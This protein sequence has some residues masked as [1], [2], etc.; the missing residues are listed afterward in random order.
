MGDELN[1]ECAPGERAILGG[2]GLPWRWV[3]E[4]ALRIETGDA[5]LACHAALGAAG[6]PE[7]EDV[8]PA[9]GSLLL[10][11]R[12]GAGVP[13]G[14]AVALAARKILAPPPGVVH[15]IPVAYGGAAGPDLAVLARK[16]GLD[17]AAYVRLHC[18][19][20]HVVAFVGFQP[21]FP[22]LRGLPEALHAPRRARP[23][24]RVP[25]GS[26]A[27]GG[28]YTGIYPTGG[29][30]G[31]HLI[32]HVAISLFDPAREAPALLRPGDRVRFVAI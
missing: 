31:W 11:L 15:E 23:R 24:I 18:G 3:G 14:L 30:G 17:D 8:I 7:I 29:P 22:Y 13:A 1:V 16:A 27:L 4:R 12:R 25:A 6:F 9:D 2:L 10:V 19:V 20:E 28:A 26:V 21:G 5:T 32:G